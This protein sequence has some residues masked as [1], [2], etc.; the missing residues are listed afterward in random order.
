MEK[1]FNKLQIYLSSTSHLITDLYPSFVI[2]LIPVLTKKFELSLFM[3]G[4]L[5]SV[6]LI[7][8]SLTQPIF[9]YLSDRHGGKYFMVAG[10]LF[11]S[12]FISMIGI[13][14][15]YYMLLAA[16]F[17]GNLSVAAFHPPS[18]AIASHYGESKKSLGNSIISF[19]GNM[20]YSIG[21]LFVILIVKKLGLSFTP[22]TMIPGIIM[23]LIL[24]KFI[25]SPPIKEASQNKI[26]LFSK[27]KKI[28]KTRIISLILIWF[29]SYSRDL[30]WITLLTFMPL[31]F[32]DANITLINIGYILLMFGLA[33]G[34]GGL[35]VGYY[36]DKIK[37]SSILIQLGLI[38]SVPLLH[39]IFKTSGF[40]SIILFIL[41]GF[42]LIST[43][44]LCIRLSQSIFPGNI[45]LASSLVMGL[46]AGSAGVTMIF[47]GK[48]ADYI[49]IIRTI[50]F[51][52]ILPI[53]A[54]FLLI[55]FPKFYRK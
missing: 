32:T 45:G 43:L 41:G 23:S 1:R 51:V 48:V 21:S 49:G 11:A 7:S 25:P 37:K 39:F 40:I 47:L 5:T 24:I 14:P 8:N 2:G 50:N 12:I 10:P 30:L 26:R 20:G 29:T 42:F 33:G 46:S 55:F 22:I 27:I 3:V 38:I 31:Y 4:L 53:I 18:A 52:L 36:A 44:P 17:L 19:G 54:F 9:G 16:L 13:L 28:R 35:F 34:I 15:N 6:N